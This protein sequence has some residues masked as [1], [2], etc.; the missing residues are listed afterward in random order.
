MIEDEVNLELAT[1][2]LHGVLPPDES[3]ASAQLQQELLHVNLW[4][5]VPHFGN[6]R[7]NFLI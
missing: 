5:S 4:D 3:E 7:Y 2:Y 6:A 1:A